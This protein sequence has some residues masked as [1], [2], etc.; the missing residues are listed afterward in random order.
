MWGHT[1]KVGEQFLAMFQYVIYGKYMQS[2]VDSG[3]INQYKFL[4]EVKI[5]GSHSVRLFVNVFID[6]M[7]DWGAL[8]AKL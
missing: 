7:L 6:V 5:E 1:F 2:T 4:A 8:G 3:N